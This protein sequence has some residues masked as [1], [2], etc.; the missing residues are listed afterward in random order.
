MRLFK[1]ALAAVGLSLLIALP[2]AG[3]AV[4]A[5]SIFHACSDPVAAGSDLC[6]GVGETGDQTATNNS[7]YGPNGII[8][9]I[10]SIFSRV[11]GF[12]AVLMIIIGGL[13]YVMSQGDSNNINSAKNTI[14]YAI[15]G[16]VVAIM[17]QSIV[18]FVLNKIA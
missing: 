15:V 12:T 6:K 11:I 8:T 5:D 10:V 13:K 7:L 18:V 9:K 16:V 14:L 17:G 4:A 1:R 2:F 3:V